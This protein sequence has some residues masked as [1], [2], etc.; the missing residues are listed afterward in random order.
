MY[1][2]EW[3]ENDHTG[4]GERFLK[5]WDYEKNKDL[6]MKKL[7]TG[8]NRYAWF[9]CEN[10]HEWKT[11]VR[12]IVNGSWCTKCSNYGTSYTEQLI[13]WWACL[14]FKSVYNRKVLIGEEVDIYI[15]DINLVIEYQSKSYHKFREN[16]HDYVKLKRLRDAGFNVLWVVEWVTLSKDVDILY[17]NTKYRNREGNHIILSLSKYL[18]SIYHLNTSGF[19]TDEVKR[20]A[21]IFSNCIKYENS[22]EYWLLHTED[23]EFAEK[24]IK[25]LESDKND[26]LSKV[27]R[28]TTR[29]RLHMKCCD[30]GYEWTTTPGLLTSAKHFC[31]KCA[32]KSKKSK[33]TVPHSYEES[34]EYWLTHTENKIQA[35]RIEACF[36]K[37]CWVDLSKIKPKSC[38][39]KLKMLCPV[40]KETWEITPATLTAGSFNRKHK[41]CLEK[42]KGENYYGKDI[43]CS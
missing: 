33:L 37:S 42:R 18:N 31:H 34:F 28:G 13:Y 43:V 16:K 20:Q 3:C 1:V 25:S 19:L 23:R 30:C 15:E 21:H 22:L 14:Q 32:N 27:Y 39:I 38:A 35:E 26:D 29:V 41:E 5:G 40:C 17:R 4:K 9:R 2:K 8:S 36:D 6:D 24:I 10:G 7:K 11:Q 12:N